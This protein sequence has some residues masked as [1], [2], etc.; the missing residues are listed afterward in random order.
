MP[1]SVAPHRASSVREDV[2]NLPNMLTFGRIAVIPLICW[3]MTLGDRTAG[4]AA[5]TIFGLAGFTDW[6]D[7]YIARRRGLVSLTGKFLDPLADKLLVM[8]VLIVLIPLDRMPAWIVVVLV[9]REISITSLRA[10]A[11]GEGLIIAS[12]MG[13]KWKAGFQFVALTCL[14]ID[15][16]YVV[17]Y[18]L[19]TLEVRF[20]RIGLVLLLVSLGYALTS[21]WQYVRGFLAAIGAQSQPGG[22]A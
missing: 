14:I 2:W 16:A 8:A 19:F 4:I 12:A 22:S 17:D 13:G 9:A 11:A 6:L 15:H 3:L 5:A 21:G 1:Q 20:Q 7:G 10:L 18:G